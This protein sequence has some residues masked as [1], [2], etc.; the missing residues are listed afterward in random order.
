MH[1][2]ADQANFL[3][4]QRTTPQLTSVSDF[5]G[6]TSAPSSSTKIRVCIFRV[7]CLQERFSGAARLSRAP[8]NARHSAKA[9]ACSASHVVL[10]SC[11]RIPDFRI[12]LRLHTHKENVRSAP[13]LCGHADFCRGRR[14]A[15]RAL[16][17]TQP[18]DD[19]LKAYISLTCGDISTPVAAM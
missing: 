6:P 19:G 17:I 12:K 14:R 3:L 15:R 7:F 8:K 13:A 1:S 4:R 5:Q 10:R 11:R 2:S 16:K 9:R 18:A